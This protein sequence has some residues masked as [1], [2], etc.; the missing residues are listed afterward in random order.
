MM[1]SS[2]CQTTLTMKYGK[3][4]IEMFEKHIQATIEILQYI[5]ISNAIT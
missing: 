5:L 2:R 1:E 3:E 4:M